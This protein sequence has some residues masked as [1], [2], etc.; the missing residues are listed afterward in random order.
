MNRL[1]VAVMTVATFV[2]LA[3]GGVLSW[4]WGGGPVG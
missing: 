4:P 2:V 1:A 3:V